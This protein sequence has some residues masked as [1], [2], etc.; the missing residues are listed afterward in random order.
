VSNISAATLESAL[1]TSKS[2]STMLA[3]EEVFTPSPSDLRVRSELTPTEKRAIRTKERKARKRTRDALDKGVDKYRKVNTKGIRAIK[4]QK[5]AALQ[6]V[7]KSSKGVTVVGKKS[8]DILGKKE[9][10]RYS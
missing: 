9:G 7:V 3:P 10:K 6:S 5:E 8:K 4:K 1:P 2:A